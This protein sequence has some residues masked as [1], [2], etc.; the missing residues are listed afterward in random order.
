MD[1]KLQ[2]VYQINLILKFGLIGGGQANGYPTKNEINYYN[3]DIN[4]SNDVNN[5]HS[6]SETQHYTQKKKISLMTLAKNYGIKI[7]RQ[8]I[9]LGKYMFKIR[10]MARKSL[11]R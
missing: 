6:I 5:A 2:E 1:N 3:I 7:G 10:Y 9:L 4:T 8:F 11:F